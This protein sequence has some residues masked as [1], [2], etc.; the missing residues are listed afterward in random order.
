MLRR[1]K[2][3]YITDSQNLVYVRYTLGEQQNEFV[4]LVFLNLHFQKGILTDAPLPSCHPSFILI[5]VA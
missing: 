2:I 5:Q 1:F 4:I 3:I